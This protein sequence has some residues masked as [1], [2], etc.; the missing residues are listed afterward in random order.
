[1]KYYEVT[2]FNPG[3][4][5]NLDDTEVVYCQAEDKAEL[6]IVA[7]YAHSKPVKECKEVTKSVFDANQ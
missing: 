3:P 5:I 4:P 1:M 7:L 2:L 6:L